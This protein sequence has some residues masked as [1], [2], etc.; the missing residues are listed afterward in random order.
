MVW[1]GHLLQP[2]WPDVSN[3][4][5]SLVIVTPVLSEVLSMVLAADP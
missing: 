1:A 4:M 3:P 2:M 5:A